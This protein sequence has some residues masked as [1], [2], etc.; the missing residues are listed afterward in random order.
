MFASV[1]GLKEFEIVGWHRYIVTYSDRVALVDK[2]LNVVV[3]AYVGS[4][5]LRSRI[6]PIETDDGVLIRL[7]PDREL[8]VRRVPNTLVLLRRNGEILSREI[9]QGYSE[10][11]SD[12]QRLGQLDFEAEFEQLTMRLP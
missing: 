8:P 7:G 2:R 5:T 11:A 9:P 3:F 12:V 6:A 10:A 1:F 4:D